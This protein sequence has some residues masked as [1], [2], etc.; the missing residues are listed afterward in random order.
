MEISKR[1][2]KLFKEKIVDWQE[3]YMDR[4][5]QEYLQLLSSPTGNPS[6]R[7]WKLEKRIMR[8][9]KHPGVV[10]QMRRSS[11]FYDIAS[12]VHLQVITMDDLTDFSEELQ[13]AVRL[14]LRR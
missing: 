1:D 6:D 4:L 11:A 2:W 14:I 5:N 9:R 10:M 13:D 8:D 7:F 3:N 12:L